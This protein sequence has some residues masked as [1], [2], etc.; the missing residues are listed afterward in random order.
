MVL[1]S[2]KDS[3]PLGH[4]S[5]SS[6][7]TA[8]H[9]CR[10]S[11]WLPLMDFRESW[12]RREILY[13][14]VHRD[15]VSRFKQ[16]L[17]G[18]AWYI[19]QPLLTAIIFM[20]V[21]G[22]IA[23]IPTDG[24]PPS[25]FYLGGILGWNYFAGTLAATSNV[26]QSNLHLFGKVYFPRVLVPLSSVFSQAMGWV[27]QL[28]TFLALYAYH[29]LA[30]NISGDVQPNWTLFCL[31]VYIV[32]AGATALGA[33]LILS[34]LTAK[35]RD[36]QQIQPFILQAWLYLTPLVYPLSQVPQRFRS[37]IA[38]NPMTMVLENIKYAFFNVGI[39]DIWL[40]LLSLGISGTILFI[41]LILFQN[42]QRSFVDTV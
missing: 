27:I 36:L 21:F 1:S 38:L 19:L 32:Q 24:V 22:R 8:S 5:L 40:S 7:D 15:F 12:S 29:A 2:V 10:R 34:S 25:L 42:A 17:L 39:P 41:G 11:S 6:L 35:Y 37:L 13:V 33:G 28:M 3:E 18:P 14:L 20:L 4:R 23:G 30:G 9:I 26:F 16:T 31:P